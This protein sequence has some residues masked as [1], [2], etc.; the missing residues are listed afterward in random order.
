MTQ[1][2]HF[3]IE[4]KCH[5]SSRLSCNYST[6][7]SRCHLALSYCSLCTQSVTFHLKRLPVTPSPPWQTACWCF[8]SQGSW[9]TTFSIILL[10]S[11]GAQNTLMTHLSQSGSQPQQR[12]LAPKNRRWDAAILCTA[13]AKHSD[14]FKSVV[15]WPVTCQGWTFGTL[16]LW[17]RAPEAPFTATKATGATTTAWSALQASSVT[18]LKTGLRNNNPLQLQPCL[19]QVA[20]WTRSG[21]KRM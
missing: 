18:P 7:R 12:A 4:H 17:W 1:F 8:H 19:S 21:P 2:L 10:D 14:S 15:C 9:H 20:C 5:T 13:P 16:F 11:I 6:H 3:K